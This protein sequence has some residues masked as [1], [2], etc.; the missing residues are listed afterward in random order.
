MKLSRDIYID[1]GNYRDENSFRSLYESFYHSL[2]GIAYKYVGPETA[3]DIV[4]DTFLRLWNS[5]DS[6]TGIAD[7][8]MYLYR[9]VRNGCLNH[10]RDRRVEDRYRS[11]V[12]VASE[13]LFYQAVMHEEVFLQMRR[14]IDDLPVIYRDVLAFSLEGLSDKE[15]SEKLKISLDNV[16]TRKK[17]GKSMLRETLKDPRLL[18]FLNLL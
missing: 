7:L 13:E 17:R 14:A 11:G 6:Y 16:K 3:R 9:A 18:L 4:Q 2:L 8:R 15:V 12:D 10:I 1:D 5:P